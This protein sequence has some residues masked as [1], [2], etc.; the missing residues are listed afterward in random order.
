G[1]ESAIADLETPD[2]AETPVARVTASG[3]AAL[4]LAITL[5]ASPQ[6]RRVVVVR[7]CYSGTDALVAG[8]LG[9]LGMQLTTVDITPAK[10]ADHGA[11]VAAALGDDVCAVVTEV[12]T[13][14]LM[15]LMDVSAIAIAAH[16]AG[17]ACIVDST[18]TTP[19]LF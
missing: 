15:T 10:G 1:L 18:F 9:N 3:Q 19:F 5:V 4:G 12:I 14:P 16:A 7:P 13:N 6:R 17:A 8:P 2:R 11:V